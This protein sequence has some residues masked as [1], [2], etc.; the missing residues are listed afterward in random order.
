MRPW[1]FAST[2]F[3]PCE[4]GVCVC[5]NIC[6]TLVGFFVLQGDAPHLKSGHL[7]NNLFKMC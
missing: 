7:A 6:P 1:S 5:V 4:G 3:S 2:T